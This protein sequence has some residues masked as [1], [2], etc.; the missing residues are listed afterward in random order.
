MPVVHPQ[1]GPDIQSSAALEFQGLCGPPRC[2]G[3]GNASV[4]SLELNAEHDLYL[5]NKKKT[6]P[7]F[8]VHG[9]PWQRDIQY[10]GPMPPGKAIGLDNS[11]LG[12]LSSLFVVLTQ[13]V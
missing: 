2:A 5:L 9:I 8:E 1:G 3:S 13:A 4:Q 12:R 6:S 10:N 11:P 7:P